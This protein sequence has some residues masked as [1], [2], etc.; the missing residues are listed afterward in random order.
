MQE[1]FGY[2]AADPKTPYDLTAW[3][4]AY[5]ELIGSFI[6]IHNQEVFLLE[7]FHE[8]MPTSI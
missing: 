8:R 6:D 1:M 7:A 5:G 3:C 2:L 4:N